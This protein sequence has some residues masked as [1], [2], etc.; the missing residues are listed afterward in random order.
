MTNDRSPMAKS[1]RDAFG[2]AM[3]ELG[4]ANP[5]VL[6]LTADLGPSVRLT[7]FAREFPERYFNVGVAE[8]NLIGLGAGLALE[9]F[10][11]F[12]ASFAVFVS[13]RC[14][15]QIRVSVCQNKANVKLVGSHLGFT[16]AGDGATAQS[17][18]D[19]ALMRT[20]PGMTIICPADAREVKKAV[21]KMA[22]I[23]GP[24][25]LRLS[26]AETPVFTPEAA[27]FEIG[28]AQVLRAGKK[29]TIVAC[30][31]LVYAA[32]E[33]AEKID[34]EVISLSTIKPLDKETVLTSAK[35]TGRVLTLEEHSIYGGMGSA[36]AEFLSQEYPVPVK[37]IGIPDVFG[38]SARSYQELLDKY[39]LTTEN[40][41]KIADGF[42]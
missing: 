8:A 15:D 11:P 21:F 22:E 24:M 35:K 19:I 29:V 26:R 23:P 12:C 36:V 33:A 3:L 40:M 37:I 25:Y 1:M 2:A 4:K 31:S 17:I 16:N 30:G 28:Q 38:E 39:G 20:L 18:E 34:G 27:K 41:V 10:I 7:E 5:S 42:K 32:L 6:A 14:F 13:G 9:G